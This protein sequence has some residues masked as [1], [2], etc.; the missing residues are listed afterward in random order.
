MSSL[1]TDT[2]TTDRDAHT[3]ADVHTN[4]DAHTDGRSLSHAGNDPYLWKH[5]NTPARGNRR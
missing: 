2:Y 4:R 1:Y 3:H 5:L